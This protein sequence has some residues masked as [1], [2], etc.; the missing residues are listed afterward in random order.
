MSKNK[1]YMHSSVLYIV[2]C[3]LLVTSAP[4]SVRLTWKCE[5]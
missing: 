2:C 1:G 4:L 3:E 5:L